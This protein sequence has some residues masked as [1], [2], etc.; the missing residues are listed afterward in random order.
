MKELCA[1]LSILA[2]AQPTFAQGGPGRSGTIE[3]L[4]DTPTTL[5]LDGVPAWSALEKM[6]G[7]PEIPFF[8]DAGVVDSKVTIRLRNAPLREGIA[9]L[10]SAT[11]SQARVWGGVLY[12]APPGKELPPPPE[13]DNESE[14]GRRLTQ[15]TK[16]SLNFTGTELTE[17]LRFLQDVA[18]RIQLRVSDEAL[19]RVGG[20]QIRLR[21]HLPS[22]TV[23]S[24]VTL[25]HGLTW[26][27]HHGAWVAITPAGLPLVPGNE[28]EPAPS[29]AQIEA[30][31]S[32][33]YSMTLNDDLSSCGL[34]IA[35]W[36]ATELVLPPDLPRNPPGL[37][38][39]P[40]HRPLLRVDGWTGRQVLDQYVALFGGS[41]R[42]EEH[43]IVIS[44]D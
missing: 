26:E 5:D 17:V 12:F 42:K 34:Q 41:W 35:A 27:V 7:S 37:G 33:A 43:R 8:V 36:M 2:L 40:R 19:A 6:T 4:L 44:R 11:R 9:A 39:G 14:L 32:R 38:N 10:A 23:L 24:L 30:A 16:F 25:P 21:G 15:G 1:A 3:E 13:I 28:V 29:D 31:L 22:G 18:S 20:L